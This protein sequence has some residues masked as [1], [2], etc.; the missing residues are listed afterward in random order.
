MDIETATAL[1]IKNDF[2]IISY[3]PKILEIPVAY[4]DS[5]VG[6][7]IDTL[8]KSIVRIIKKKGEK[9]IRNGDHVGLCML[10][11]KEGV[12]VAPAE[13]GKMCHTIILSMNVE[14]VMH[15]VVPVEQIGV[16]REGYEVFSTFSVFW[17]RMK[18]VADDL[19][20]EAKKKRTIKNNPTTN[21]RNG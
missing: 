10:L 13:L 7:V 19:L 5:M 2:D 8:Q 4:M 9:F 1:A 18:I 15:K 16:D 17:V 12:K 6:M 21:K 20:V 14:V 11:E 3:Q